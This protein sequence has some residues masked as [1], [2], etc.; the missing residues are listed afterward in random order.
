MENNYIIQTE[1]CSTDKVLN[2]LVK[3]DSTFSRPL[4]SHLNLKK[5]SEKLA[6][7]ANFVICEENDEVVGFIAYYINDADQFCF[8]TLIS[9][10]NQYRRK[11][12]GEKMFSYLLEKIKYPVKLEVKVSNSLAISFYT[13][14]GFTKLH[15]TN[16]TYTLIRR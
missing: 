10:L 1:K 2:I 15:S 12:L 3:F 11:G 6:M 9:V 8:I 16:D 14:L 7:N 5:F 13:H 4:S